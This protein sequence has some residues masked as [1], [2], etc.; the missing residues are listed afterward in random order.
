MELKDDL[1]HVNFVT[2]P[3]NYATFSINNRSNL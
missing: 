3:Y 1:Q 2:I